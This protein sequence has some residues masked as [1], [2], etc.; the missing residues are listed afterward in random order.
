MRKLIAITLIAAALPA[1]AWGAWSSGPEPLQRH[2]SIAGPVASPYAVKR[3]HVAAA[4]R[5]I[6]DVKP[7]HNR[8]YRRGPFRVRILVT[9]HHYRV[10]NVGPGQIWANI[11]TERV[12]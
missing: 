8:V 4:H 12:R 11:H 5:T 3:I 9:Q 6:A 7:S 2:E 10:A 1:T